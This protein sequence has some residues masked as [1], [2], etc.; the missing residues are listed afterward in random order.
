MKNLVVKKGDSQ[1]KINYGQLF[2]GQAVLTPI[3]I[4]PS[5]EEYI[6]MKAL[7]NI[8]DNIPERQYTGITFNTK[9]GEFTKIEFF[10]E[11]YPNDLVDTKGM[12]F[13]Y[14]DK[15]IESIVVFLGDSYVFSKDQS[16]IQII[17]QH[18]QNA[19]IEYEEGLTVKEM[20]E[21][22]EAKLQDANNS[23][24]LSLISKIDKETA[25]HAKD[26][27][28]KLYSVLFELTQLAP[29]NAVKIK[30]EQGNEKRLPLNGFV[31]GSDVK[32]KKDGS[33]EYLN[34]SPD[35]AHK[36]LDRIYKGDFSELQ[37]IFDSPICKDA[38]GNQSKVYGLIGVRPDKNDPSK[39]YQAIY[40]GYNT[41]GI[42]SIASRP[43]QRNGE[44]VYMGK[45]DYESLPMTKNFEYQNTFKF[46]P[47]FNDNLGSSLGTVPASSADDDL[48]F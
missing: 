35:D 47:Y 11:F 38:D 20:L 13:K 25:R 12:N 29:H 46:Q 1:G 40:S 7:E 36:A 14:E 18:N 41:P 28:V 48:P 4:N 32:Q 9:E 23:G 44:M 31:I 37:A 19:Y 6:K 39:K 34:V 8:A 10:F 30:D 22:F 26:G 33:I 27:E 16:K 42:V 43:Q 3:A 15:V 21:K 2:T 24:Y 5:T 17:D 45:S